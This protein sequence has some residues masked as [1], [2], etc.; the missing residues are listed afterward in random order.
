MVDIHT[1]VLYG[2][3]DG[4]ET[5][6]DS[7]ALLKEAKIQGIDT[8]YATPHFYTSDVDIESHKSNVENNFNNLLGCINSDA[9]PNVYL[10]Y[11]VHY[12]NN[13]YKSDQLKELT[14]NNTEYLLL[15]LDYNDIT[16]KVINNI[17][18]IRWQ[19][20]LKPI[21]AH[22]ERYHNLKGFKK[23]LS[24]I[25]HENIFSQITVS[26]LLKKD[27][28]YKVSKKLIKK[29]LVDF[30]A[31]DMHHIKKRPPLFSKAL[32]QLRKDHGFTVSETLISN[33]HKITN[34]R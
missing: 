4:A 3:D 12:F 16:D 33:S 25:D 24:I 7:L 10:G 5:L 18:E 8:V 30:L 14:L 32:E 22:I 27:R 26:S 15:E 29:G 34:S 31:S 2:V 19:Q 13:I 28:Y 9:Y 17:E 11:E 1:H 21:I 20:G 23:L 6:E